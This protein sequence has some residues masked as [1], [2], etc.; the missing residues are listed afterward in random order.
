MHILMLQSEVGKINFL[1]CGEV[2]QRKR[3]IKFE[4]G[5]G[6]L[7]LMLGYL[8]GGVVFFKAVHGVFYK[9]NDVIVIPH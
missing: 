6:F 1:K 4:S 9:K 3:N 2:E 5:S 7:Y 8:G